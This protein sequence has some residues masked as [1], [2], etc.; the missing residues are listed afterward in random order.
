[1][2]L[3]EQ[4]RLDTAHR[5]PASSA[6]SWHHPLKA[7]RKAASGKTARIIGRTC[8]RF[9]G[10]STVATMAC[11]LL[12]LVSTH[13]AAQVAVSTVFVDAVS[14][15]GEPIL[16]LNGSAAYPVS[17][18]YQPSRIEVDGTVIVSEGDAVAPIAGATWASTS[19]AGFS[20]SGRLILS[21]FLDG[22]DPDNDFAT[23]I[24]GG[25]LAEYVLFQKGITMAPG[26]SGHLSGVSSPRISGSG[27]IAF[28]GGVVETGA[29][30]VWAGMPGALCGILR[31]RPTR[32]SF[33]T[34]GAIPSR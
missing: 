12:L 18:I 11:V 26:T 23:V 13:A 34:P 30:G 4:R 19:F 21:G 5:T 7:G 27:R 28:R 24:L 22:T 2:K 33:T 14:Q 17:T 15:A 16:N 9:S 25:G 1:M 29:A 3:T 10:C 32:T 6:E 31:V 20:D 8:V